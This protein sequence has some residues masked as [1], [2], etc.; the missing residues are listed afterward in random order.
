VLE[1]LGR[2]PDAGEEVEVG[3]V[4]FVVVS[5]EDAQIQ[6]L[7]LAATPERAPGAVR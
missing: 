1:Y 4:R 2:L 3:G 6:E 5:A 7:R